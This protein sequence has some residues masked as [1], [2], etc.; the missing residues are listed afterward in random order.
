MQKSTVETEKKK[1]ITNTVR[2]NCW[3]LRY[4]RDVSREENA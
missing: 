1:N 4:A 3:S 2:G